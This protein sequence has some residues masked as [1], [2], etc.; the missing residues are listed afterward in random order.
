MGVVGLGDMGSGLAKNLL[1]AGF[2]VTGHDLKPE[3]M[4]A[5]E[6][7]GGQPANAAAGVG[8]ASDVVFVMVMNGDQAR[9][10]IFDA[11]LVSTMAAGGTIVMTATIRASEMRAIAADLAASG[12]DIVDS[13][14]S[15]G[16][17]GAQDG[18]L[19]MMAAGTDAALEKCR[20]AMQA[21]GGA[22]H[23]V[24]AEP[25]MGQTVKACLQT[26]I[27]S[28]FSATFE[29]S[30]LAAKAGVEAQVLYDVF[31]SSGAGSRV[32]NTALG[33]IIE[34]K[35]EGT[36][37]HIATM[38]KDLTIALDLAREMGVPLF[39]AATAMQLFQAGITKYPDSDNWA[40]TRVV[41]DIVGASL[42]RDRG[43]KPA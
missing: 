26:L 43:E 3:R 10:V 7:M 5:F 40:V 37:S 4:A 6:A 9:G 31:S 42:R 2:Q 33:N 8:A 21:V 17:A 35:F 38:H 16:Y 19:T 12:L 14:V 34:G 11:G 36:G 41:E 39:T 18:S 22:I 28:I 30:V 27:G 32:A 20:P 25:G 24:G 15:G 13:P 29:A 1:A 23:R